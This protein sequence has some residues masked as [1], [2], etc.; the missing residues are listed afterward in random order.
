MS[1]ADLIK[2]LRQR[3]IEISVGGCGCCGSPWVSIRID[4]ELVVD[5]VDEYKIDMVNGDE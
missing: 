3:G 2:L 1:K 4:G 5:N